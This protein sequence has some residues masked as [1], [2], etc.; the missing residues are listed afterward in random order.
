MGFCS[1]EEYQTFFEAVPDFERMLARS[2]IKIVKYWFSSP[3]RS[4]RL[5]SGPVLKIP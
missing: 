4:R 1:D 5:A 2:G 3:I